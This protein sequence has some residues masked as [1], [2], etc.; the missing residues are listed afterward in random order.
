ML[1]PRSGSATVDQRKALH[2]LIQRVTDDVAALRYNTAIAALMG[3]VHGRSALFQEEA[4]ALPLLLAPFAPHLAEELWARLGRAYSVHQQ[5]WPTADPSLVAPEVQKVAVQV[6]GRTRGVIELAPGASE[7][8]ALAAAARLE[9]VRP[10]LSAAAR[11]IYRPGRVLNLVV[12]G[13]VP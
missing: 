4:D 3:Y 10:H 11:V 13:N 8:E 1:G 6:D 7:A 5:A 12:S 9:V 2:R